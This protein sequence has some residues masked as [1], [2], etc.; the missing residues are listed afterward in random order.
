M[1]NI[2]IEEKRYL[3]ETILKDININFGKNEIVSIIG[4][5]GCGKTTLLNLISSLD[6]E[7][8][9]KI[10]FDKKNQI[11]NLGFMFQDSRLLPWLSVKDNI[12]L[13]QKEKDEDKIE[14][15]LHKV[16]LDRYINAKT[17]ELSGG[18]K[19]RVALIRAFINNPEVLL[20]DEPFISLDAPTAKN[21]RILFLEFYK[22][23]PTNTIFITH[24]LQ[25]ALSVSDRIIFLSYKPTTILYEYKNSSKSFDENVLNEKKEEILK[26]YPDILS[27][28][29]S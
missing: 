23:N 6:K 27:G 9:G 12:C 17:N 1:L 28:Y 3:D 16:G 26:R 22:Q 21:L 15:M 2:N 18:M 8:H 20:L 13:V 10:E 5:S 29:L 24:D 11:E 14:N 19:R 25:E 4:P 7:F